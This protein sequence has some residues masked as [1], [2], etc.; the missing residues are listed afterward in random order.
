M[1]FSETVFVY[2]SESAARADPDLHAGGRAAVRRPPDARLGVRARRPASARR[3]HGSRPARASSRPLERERRGSS[4]G[5]WSSRSRRG[6]LRPRGRAACRARGRRLAISGR[7]LRQRPPALFVTLGSQE[8]VA[9]AQ[10]RPR[11]ASAVADARSASTARRLGQPWK[12]RMFIPGGG[13]A[14]DPATGSAAGP[15]ALHLARHGRS[16]SGTRS[17][18]PGRRDPAPVEAVRASGRKRE[19]VERV[20]VGGR[21]RR[22]PRRVPL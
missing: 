11:R 12:T 9:R 1:N 21:R 10:A 3:D 7:R 14:E 15:L 20:E 6:A 17:R 13:V 2:P 4:S 19:H 22:R 8:A 16:R 18:S 5:G